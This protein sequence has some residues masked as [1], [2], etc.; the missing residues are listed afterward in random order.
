MGWGQPVRRPAWRY[1]RRD[2]YRWAVE[3]GVV[4]WSS[5]VLQVFSWIGSESRLLIVSPR[6]RPGLRR[7]KTHRLWKTD[8]SQRRYSILDFHTFELR[9]IAKAK[10][11]TKYNDNIVYNKKYSAKQDACMYKPN[12]LPSVA[13]LY[14]RTCP[15][16]RRQLWMRRVLPLL[17]PSS[18]RISAGSLN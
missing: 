14:H 17:F 10:D 16:I 8:E 11:I 2:T 9:T 7:D 6:R 3:A 12:I 5:V 15:Q 18:I 4:A 1:R 13:I